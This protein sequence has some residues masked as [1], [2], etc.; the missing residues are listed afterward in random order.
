[1]TDNKDSV[2]VVG[3]GYMAKEYIK[4]L[5]GLG[6][7]YTVVG[8][9][10]ESV[11]KLSADTGATAIPGGIEKYIADATKDSLPGF[12]IV[13]INADRIFQATKCLITAGIKEI[14]IEK[15]GI[16]SLNQA[17]ELLKTADENNAE[18]FI[19]YNRRFYASVENLQKIAE[20]DGGIESVN[21]EFTEWRNTVEATTHPDYLKQI[22]F[23]MN[24]T[25]VV[26][27]AFYLTGY[28]KEIQAYSQGGLPWH[29]CGSNYSGCG[30]TDKGILFSYQANWD[31]PGRWGVE[32][33]TRQHRLYLRPLEKLAI[34]N[35]CS[36][37]IESYDIDDSYDIEYKAGL[38]EEVKAFLGLN[39]R[40]SELCTLKE[41]HMMLPVYSK[42]SGETY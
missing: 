37:T 1:M 12:A 19:A 25:H 40:R 31:A 13:A 2:L 4:V 34:Q 9:R 26:D 24:S 17:E 21:F 8:N 35:K 6:R 32:V 42:I 14:L 22:W 15:P 16:I 7:D 10:Q 28:P 11:D 39:N 27:L 3:T 41:Q 33:L 36:V 23:L 38:F 5:R 30:I 18:V 20:E 29:S